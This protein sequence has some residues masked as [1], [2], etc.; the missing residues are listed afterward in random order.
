MATS[1]VLP[2][3]VT[4][5]LVDQSVTGVTFEKKMRFLLG[6][7]GGLHV[8]YLDGGPNVATIIRKSDS[9]DLLVDI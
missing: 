6:W 7:G 3:C 8:L 1:E 4:C 9:F 5:N 2:V